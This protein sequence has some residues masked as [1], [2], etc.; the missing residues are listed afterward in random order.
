MRL[1]IY[2]LSAA[3]ITSTS[4]I[5]SSVNNNAVRSFHTT[6]KLVAISYIQAL[7]KAQFR[8]A[9]TAFHSLSKPTFHSSSSKLFVSAFSAPT[10]PYLSSS[11][12]MS[13]SLSSSFRH[14]RTSSLLKWR[15]GDNIP[16]QNFNQQQWNNYG[17]GN[18]GGKWFTEEKK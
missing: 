11:T 5:I 9:V 18:Q 14:F 12:H 8:C 15:S 17:G 1:D 2:C 3:F 4:P 7:P 13:V 6:I 16:Q 10:T